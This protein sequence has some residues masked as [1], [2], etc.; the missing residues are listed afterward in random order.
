MVTLDFSI[1]FSIDLIFVVEI[2]HLKVKGRTRTGPDVTTTDTNK[3]KR[4]RIISCRKRREAGRTTGGGLGGC[5]PDCLFAL[6]SLVLSNIQHTSQRFRA[7][8]EPL[9]N[10]FQTIRRISTGDSTV[11]ETENKLRKTKKTPRQNIFDFIL[12]FGDKGY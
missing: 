3:N 12:R 11:D 10:E 9:L 4:V 5:V 2:I 7:S 6:S 1:D 8:N